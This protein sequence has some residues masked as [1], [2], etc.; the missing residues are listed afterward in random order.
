MSKL[1]KTQIRTNVV[2]TRLQQ[3]C[4]NSPED[5]TFISGMLDEMLDNLRADDFFGTE[6]QNDP[7]GD[8][9]NGSWQMDHVEGIDR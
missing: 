6:A 9:R 4:L 1:T 7:R 8:H 2:L 3:V 5:A